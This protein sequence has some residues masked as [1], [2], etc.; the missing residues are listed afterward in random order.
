MA[1]I[2]RNG[3]V[4]SYCDGFWYA[5]SNILGFLDLSMKYL[6]N[7]TIRRS[8]ATPMSVLERLQNVHC[9]QIQRFGPTLKIGHPK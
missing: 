8:L 1:K 2:G 5:A 9:S 4:M 7:V 3:Y 6:K